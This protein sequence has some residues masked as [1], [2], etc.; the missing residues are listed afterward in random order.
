VPRLISPLL[1]P[2]LMVVAISIAL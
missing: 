1:Q 2:C